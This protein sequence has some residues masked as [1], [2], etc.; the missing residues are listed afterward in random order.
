MPLFTSRSKSVKK[1]KQGKDCCSELSASIISASMVFLP[2]DPKDVISPPDG[3]DQNEWI[4]FCTTELFET[5]QMLYS[6]LSSKCLDEEK[7]CSCMSA[8]DN[9]QY[10]WID[11]KVF[12]KPTVMSAP[13]YIGLLFEWVSEQLNNENIFPTEPSVSFPRDFQK[14]VRSIFR[15]LIRV[16]CHI[17]HAHF[18]DIQGY[19]C[20]EQL[21]S[22]ARYFVSFGKTFHLLDAEDL[23][24]LASI[25]SSW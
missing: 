11:N 13:S 22:V 10:M 3:E 23:E 15:R 6:L 4:A 24:P 12:K 25:A 2:D 17:Y 21:N 14:T 7:Q 1:T 9:Y 8:G 19:G 20:T 5:T 16:Y 18:H